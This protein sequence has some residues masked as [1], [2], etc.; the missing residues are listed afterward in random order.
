MAGLF[1][2]QAFTQWSDNPIIT[3]LE[4]VSAPIEEI[5]F[6]TITVC[7]K[8][9][10]DNWGLLEKVLNLLAFE[11]TN[12]PHSNCIENAKEIRKDFKFLITP[13]V[14]EYKELLDNI[15]YT[16]L[17]EAPMFKYEIKSYNESGVID[18]VAE[19]L[20]QG[21]FEEL[22]DVAIKKF[23]TYHALRDDTFSNIRQVEDDIRELFGTNYAAATN[24]NKQNQE[25]AVRML[26]LLRWTTY[27]LPLGSFI[28][29][30]ININKFK[31]FGSCR[32]NQYYSGIIEGIVNGCSF[33]SDL[34]INCDEIDGNEQKLHE[35][36]ALLSKSFGFNE[37][38]LLSLYELPG[39]LADDLD[40][41]NAIGSDGFPMQSDY[42]LGDIP[43]AYL[44]STCK[45]REE[46]DNFFSYSKNFLRC[47]WLQE[48]MNET[49]TYI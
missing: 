12:D 41:V 43:Q 20:N 33:W 16:T 29:Q 47:D 15:N 31:S 17:I 45:E 46:H 1:I 39:M 18:L 40:Y 11:C 7:D 34:R 10:P 44:Y 37:L 48:K 49:G 21:K 9:A 38:K 26:L 13:F 23:A 36:F 30:L 6:P 5:Q 32:Q 2:N 24:K 28:T 35:Y 22:K 8:K 4:T 42:L 27:G 19:A 25:E 14:N 3:T